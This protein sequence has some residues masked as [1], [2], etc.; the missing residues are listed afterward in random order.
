MKLPPFLHRHEFISV[1]VS[2][3]HPLASADCVR[4]SCDPDGYAL[5]SFVMAAADVLSRSRTRP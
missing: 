2:P 3:V 4:Q 5:K 1:P